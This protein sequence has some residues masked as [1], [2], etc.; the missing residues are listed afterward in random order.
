MNWYR[1]HCISALQY[2]TVALKMPPLSFEDPGKLLPENVHLA[3]RD[4]FYMKI[5]GEGKGNSTQYVHTALL[6]KHPIH[7]SIQRDMSPK[8]KKMRVRPFKVHV[9]KKVLALKKVS[10]SYLVFSKRE[11][12]RVIQLWEDKLDKVEKKMKKRGEE[13][14]MDIQGAK[15]DLA[16]AMGT[17]PRLGAESWLNAFTGDILQKIG[18]MVHG[19]VRVNDMYP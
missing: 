4:N 8:Y 5:G 13:I 15:T 18:D 10:L 19:C 14:A 6:E 17:H 9:H 16:L 2:C 12:E 7:V 3:L 11:M 1:C